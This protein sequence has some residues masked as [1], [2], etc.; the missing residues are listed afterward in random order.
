MHKIQAGIFFQ[1]SLSLCLILLL[2]YSNIIDS[3][4]ISTDFQAYTWDLDA[5]SLWHEYKNFK[6]L[7]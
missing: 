3:I 6:K 7:C 4:I 5:Y 2:Y 1:N